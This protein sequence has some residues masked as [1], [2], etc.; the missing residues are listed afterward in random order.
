MPCLGELSGSK[1][2][3]VPIK[4]TLS[5]DADTPKVTYYHHSAINDRSDHRIG[6][7]RFTLPGST[8]LLGLTGI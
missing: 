8:L 6:L 7:P 3:G 4:I 1:A 2:P 5:R